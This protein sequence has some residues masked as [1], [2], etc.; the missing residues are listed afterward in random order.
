MKA[1][2]LA[3]GEGRRC[4]PL[5][6][7][8]SKV[9]LSVRNRPFMEHVIRA[10]A[11]GGVR[12]L[13]VVVGYQKERVMDHFGDG[14]HYGVNIEYV[15]QEK[16][17][18]TADALSR[19]RSY[20]EGPILVI[21]GDNLVDERA[22]DDVLRAEG[23]NVMLAV[24]RE[25]AGDY[26]VLTVEEGRVTKIVEKPGRPFSGIIN[27]GLYRFSPDIFDELQKTPISERGSYE[28][29]Q[30]IA[31]M[32]EEGRD[33]R[34]KI[35]SG[36]WA[37]AIFAWELL[38]ANSSVP[39]IIEPRVEGE[40][41]AG[42]VVRG[43]VEIGRGSVVR[44]GSYIVGPVSI[45]KNCDIGP[46]VTVLPTTSIGDYVHIGSHTEIR[47]SI[48]MNGGRIGT[49]AVVSSSILGA[50]SSFGDHLIVESG[51]SAVVIEDEFHMAEFGAVVA[52]NVVAGARV[53]MLPGTMV[54]TGSKIGSGA[55]V[56]GWIE[57]GS[58]VI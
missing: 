35:T 40:I 25:E 17:L 32:I 54:G 20:V 3:A 30:T 55:K 57:R 48:I 58:R 22:I 6:Q 23:E 2:I 14:I 56:C 34:A 31:H 44:S 50:S 4:R 11:A 8:R 5:T 16:Q 51:E 49:G 1:V 43:P 52:D 53:M 18:G 27:T 10:L 38:E 46:N 41:E 13:V 36:V 9:M 33:V 21:N 28:L 26:G 39:G 7:T 19:V 29:T 45:G 15:V 42:A 24:L 12:D 47:N 37:D